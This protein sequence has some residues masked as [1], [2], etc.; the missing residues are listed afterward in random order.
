MCEGKVRR[1]SQH[2][3]RRK[4]R[5]EETLH[6]RG[7]SDGRKRNAQE[8]LN[9]GQNRRFSNDGPWATPRKGG[10][11]QHLINGDGW[12]LFLLSSDGNTGGRGGAATSSRRRGAEVEDARIAAGIIILPSP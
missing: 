2:H 8:P 5:E 6:H 4:P 9:Q 1:S 12:R 11:R 10:A 3:P 7:D